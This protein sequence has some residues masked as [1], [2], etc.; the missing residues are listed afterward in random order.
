MIAIVR[1]WRRVPVILATT[2]F[3]SASTLLPAAAD[4]SHVVQTGETLSGIA[5]AY[6]LPLD[7]VAAHNQITDVDVIYAGETLSI[8]GPAPSGPQLSGAYTVQPGETLTSIAA[9]RGT[10]VGQILAAN[11]SIVDPNRIYAGQSL[12]V[13]SGTGSTSAPVSTA[14]VPSLLDKYAN[15]YGLD[16][17]LVEALAWQESGWQQSVVSASGAVGVMQIMPVTADWLA[18]DVVG[19]PLDVTNNV[20]DNVEAGAAFLRFLINRT[21]S[22]Q[23]GIAAY[24]QGPGSITRDGMLPDTQQYVANVMA[25]RSYLK[26][27]GAPPVS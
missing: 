14:N 9:I 1:S 26:T 10:T 18:S 27:Y 7:A 12:N 11:P 25:I 22:E 13:P 3:L 6:G 4:S 20:A 2:A 17:A 8:P 16:P 19:R 21:G 5:A 23:L 15:Q 24:Y